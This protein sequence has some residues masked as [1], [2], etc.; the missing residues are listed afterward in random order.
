MFKD[1]VKYKDFNGNEREE[2]VRFDLSEDE[3]MDLVRIDPDFN[4]DRLSYIME[5]QDALAMYNVVRKLIVVA[6]GE[7]SEDGKH[8][9]KNDDITRDF[10]QS[11]VYRQFRDKLLE[12]SDENEIKNFLFGVLPSKV[13]E[14]IAKGTDGPQLIKGN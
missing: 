13:A 9:R 8:F 4:A 11:A 14:Q 7:I 3:L 6:Y 2:I 1:T 12:S 5:T 10:T